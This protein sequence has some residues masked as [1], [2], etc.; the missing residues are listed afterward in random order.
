MAIGPER[1]Q[2]L[3]LE[4]A[5]HMGPESAAPAKA[6]PKRRKPKLR[7]VP[8]P[9]LLQP[10]GFAEQAHATF[11][12]WVGARD[13]SIAMNVFALDMMWDRWHQRRGTDPSLYEEPDFDALVAEIY[14]ANKARAAAVL[15]YPR[16]ATLNGVRVQ[17]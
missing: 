16:L 11:T 10:V 13:T 5:R 12:N 1:L 2:E 3:A 7:E 9:K 17:A 6:K 8:K 14:A 15:R 4:L